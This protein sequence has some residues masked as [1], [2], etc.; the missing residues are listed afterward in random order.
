M[1]APTFTMAIVLMI[2]LLPA[3]ASDE[4]VVLSTVPPLGVSHQLD[5][6]TVIS[7]P[8]L[9]VL[10]EGT[11]TPADISVEISRLAFE[12]VRRVLIARDDVFSD[13]LASAG[14]QGVTSPLLLV[15]TGGPVPDGIRRRIEEMDATEAI[16]LGGEQAVEASVVDELAAM[17]LDVARVAGADRT[18]TAAAIEAFADLP[19]DTVLLAR[20]HGDGDPT[21]AWVDAVAA[22]GWAAGQ[23]LPILLTETHDLS[24]AAR[25]VLESGRYE[26]V[27]VIGGRHAVGDSVVRAVEEIGPDVERLAGD[28]RYGTAMAIA[29]R[30]DDDTGLGRHPLL[31]VPGDRPDGWVEGLV[32]ASLAATRGWRIAPIPLD[33]PPALDVLRHIFDAPSGPEVLHHFDTGPSAPAGGITYT[34]TTT[35][36]FIGGVSVGT[37]LGRGVDPALLLDPYNARV[38]RPTFRA[39]WGGD[40]PTPLLGTETLLASVV[41]VAAV[42]PPLEVEARTL[43]ANGNILCPMRRTTLEADGRDYETRLEP[44]LCD[45]SARRAVDIRLAISTPGTSVTRGTYALG[46]PPPPNRPPVARFTATTS[47]DTILVDASTSIDPDGGRLDYHF[48]FGD[49]TTDTAAATSHAYE[50]DGDYTVTLTVS[51]RRDED[52]A[53]ITVPIRVRLDMAVAA[54]TDS[55]H[56]LQI[57]RAGETAGRTL[58]DGFLVSG[59]DTTADHQVVVGTTGA[60]PTVVVT[61]LVRSGDHHAFTSWALWRGEA[62]GWVSNPSVAPDG[63]AVAFGYEHPAPTSVREGLRVVDVLG[64]PSTVRGIDLDGPVG[65]ADQAWRDTGAGPFVTWWSEPSDVVRHAS[66]G[67][68]PADNLFDGGTRPAVGPSGLVADVHS[69]AGWVRVHGGPAPTASEQFVLELGPATWSPDGTHLALLRQ[70]D[71]PGVPIELVVFDT[72]LNEVAVADLTDDGLLASSVDHP[73]EWGPTNAIAVPAGSTVGVYDLSRGGLLLDRIITIPGA[74][75]VTDVSWFPLQR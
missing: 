54:R 44:L 61:N 72:A 5:D 36:R 56:T 43:D 27:V 10:P 41:T 49:G 28:T 73:P 60:T 47:Q 65:L 48:D 42:G 55:G 58:S 2:G 74:A 68:G 1:R 12:S 64:P 70:R 16:V 29:R 32:S 35:T 21:R 52:T 30:W 67:G 33:G 4:R 8:D 17:G 69:P 18:S 45:V 62:G 11:S 71:R 22:G 38:R 75:E 6:G 51:D 23:G 19:S 34:T 46:P 25:T 15:P 14:L 24:A 26:R 7:Y 20:A 13:A 53:S 3:G 66:A 59:I 31:M 9:H 37:A 40:P 57:V 50:A 63:S 39:I